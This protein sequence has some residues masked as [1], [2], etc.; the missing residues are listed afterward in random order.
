[1]ARNRRPVRRGA[2]GKDDAS[3]QDA[4]KK[5]R[6]S[7][8]K[9]SRPASDDNRLDSAEPAAP[10]ETVGLHLRPERAWSRM[11]ASKASAGAE[12]PATSKSKGTPTPV[13][14]PQTPVRDSAVALATPK[15]RSAAQTARAGRKAPASAGRRPPQRES[16]TGRLEEPPERHRRSGSRLVVTVGVAWLAIWVVLVAANEFLDD[17]GNGSTDAPGLTLAPGQIHTAEVGGA[18]SVQETFDG[19]PMDSSLPAPWKV[20]GGGSARIIALPTSVDRSVRIESDAAGARTTACR[21]IALARGSA[22]QMSVDY[23]AGSLPTT[24]VSLLNVQAGEAPRI[25]VLL[26]PDGTVV[27]LG[28]GTGQV[29][30]TPARESA[31][32]GTSGLTAGWHR[33]EVAVDPVTGLAVWQALDS[34]GAETGSGIASVSD[35]GAAALDSVCLYSPAGVPSGWIAID[36]LLI[37]G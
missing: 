21:P 27:V 4:T 17:N 24:S 23:R 7:T 28:D 5:P 9:L 26:N 29:G 25:A 33:L 34:S 8:A 2:A 18:V 20:A 35:L 36:E 12:T 32:P 31:I 6:R 10:A 37:E 19:L 22:L 3:P 13:P 30:E 14:E 16:D 11:L 15:A 1:M